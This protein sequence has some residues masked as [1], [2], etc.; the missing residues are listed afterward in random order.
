MRVRFENVTVTGAHGSGNALPLK[1]HIDLS[2]TMPLC[3]LC[4]KG[5]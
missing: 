1:L 3:M 5:M 4:G 2:P